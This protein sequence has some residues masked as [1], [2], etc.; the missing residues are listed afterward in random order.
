VRRTTSAHP[1]DDA[2]Q[3][4][5]RY[6]RNGFL[7]PQHPVELPPV[8]VAEQPVGLEGLLARHAAVEHALELAAARDAEVPRGANSLCGQG[9]AMTRRVTGEEDAVLRSGA[10]LVRDPIALVANRVLTQ[11]GCQP[12][13][14]LLDVVARVER[15]DADAQLVVGGE[16]PPIA[17]GDV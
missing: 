14:R 7:R 8:A 17:G 11:V 1:G 9:D 5:R 3:Q 6:A 13:R 16:A 12:D 4:R 15:A 10:N 2:A